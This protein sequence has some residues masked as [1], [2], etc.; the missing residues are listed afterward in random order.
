[1]S[2]CTGLLKPRLSTGVVWPLTSGTSYRLVKVSL[3]SSVPVGQLRFRVWAEVDC[4]FWWEQIRTT[5]LEI[6][7]ERKKWNTS[8]PKACT[9]KY[10]W[11]CPHLKYGI[12]LDNGL[13]ADHVLLEVQSA[14]R[15]FFWA[16]RNC[17]SFS[18]FGYGILD[19]L[20]AL[21]TPLGQ[22]GDQALV[23]FT[24]FYFL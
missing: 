22:C 19:E 4:I 1:M 14:P 5:K 17:L 18:V 9:E 23:V 15:W 24:P 12:K 8:N 11:P 21:P 3:F 2:T 20:R 13:I 6:Q 7:R 16:W 10:C